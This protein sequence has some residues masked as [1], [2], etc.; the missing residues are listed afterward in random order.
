MA[1]TENNNQTP[2][3][4]KP[5]AL[6]SR[7]QFI[8]LGAITLGTA[9]V[10]TGVQSWLFPQTS[11]Q[12]AKPVVFALSELPVGG[13]KYAT[14]GDIPIIIMRTAE[15]IRA[16]SLV[17]THLGCT[18]QWNKGEQEFY[19]PC[20]DGYFD[21]F[22]EVTAGPPPVPLEEFPVTVENNQVTVG[23]VV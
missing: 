9:W 15:S 21:Q 11:T 5:S 22:G 16:L 23:E 2:E 18:V 3:T 19:C 4:P 7:R 17:C 10:G 20:H 13:V 8:Q 14:Y 12:E 6:A 1:D